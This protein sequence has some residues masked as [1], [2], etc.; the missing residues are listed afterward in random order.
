MKVKV[1]GQFFFPL[2]HKHECGLF[3]L[4]PRGDHIVRQYSHSVTHTRINKTSFF[5]CDKITEYSLVVL[6]RGLQDTLKYS[7]YKTW[8][9]VAVLSP[10]QRVP[11]APFR[12]KFDLN[13]VL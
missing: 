7:T 13:F 12:A 3:F 6:I 2:L 5:T 8:E 1:F 10:S 11:W 4:V 9:M